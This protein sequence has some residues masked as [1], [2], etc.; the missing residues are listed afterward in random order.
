MYV[1]IMLSPLWTKSLLT[2]RHVITHSIISH[3]VCLKMLC[4]STAR[5]KFLE[6]SEQAPYTYNLPISLSVLAQ[7]PILVTAGVRASCRR[8]LTADS[9]LRLAA[10]DKQ[11]QPATR[12]PKN[13][14][15]LL[16]ANTHTAKELLERIPMY[17]QVSGREAASA[18][19]FDCPWVFFMGLKR[20]VEGP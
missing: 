12:P 9:H 15:S 7:L 13:M 4:F 17:Y 19:R 8:Q 18:D 6:H 16:A 11:P 5:N 20:V 3:I 2:I 1:S 10:D 14:S